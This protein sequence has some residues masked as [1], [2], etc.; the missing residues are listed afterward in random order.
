MPKIVELPLGGS[1]LETDY[2]VIARGA[3]SQTFRVPLSELKALIPAGAPGKSLHTGL[4][5]PSES[6]GNAEDTYVDVN[7]GTVYVKG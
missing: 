4:G 2:F 6:V 5:P 1:A 7:T 3:N